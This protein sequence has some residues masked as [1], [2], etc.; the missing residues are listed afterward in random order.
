MNPEIKIT[1]VGTGGG[2]YHISVNGN[3]K[4]TARGIKE[5]LRIAD[6]IDT[7]PAAPIS[8]DQYFTSLIKETNQ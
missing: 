5:A 1:K 3:H 4:A 8:L 6:E 2:W 7:T